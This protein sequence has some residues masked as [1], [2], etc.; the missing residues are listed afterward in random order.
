MTK[1]FPDTRTPSKNILKISKNKTPVTN[2][3]TLP[4]DAFHLFVDDNMIQKIVHYTNIEGKREKGKE[5]QDTDSTEIQSFIGCLLHTGA[6]HQNDLSLEMLFSPVDGNSLVRAAFGLRRFSSL[7]NHLRFDD[8]ATRS[9]RRAR[10]V[11]A[12]IRELWDLFH[13]NLGKHYVAGQNITVDE[14]LVPFRG[15]CSFIQYMPSKP[16]KYGLKFFWASDAASNYPLRGFPY[17]EKEA[18][19][20]RPAE[21]TMGIAASTVERLTQDV[22]GTGRNI[23]CDNYFTDLKLAESLAKQK[24]TMIGTVKRNKTFLPVDFQAKKALPLGESK[25]LFR[26]ETTLVSFQSKRP[27]NVILLST[28]HQK[29]EICPETTKPDIVLHYNKTKGGVDAMDQM[30]HAFTTKRKTKRWPLVVFFNILDLSSIAA[31][32]IFQLK[33]PVDKLSHEDCRQRFN[34]D[35]G[36]SM[37]YAH[38][39]RR[40]SVPTLQKEVKVNISVVIKSIKPVSEQ[41][42]AKPPKRARVEESAPS[43]KKQK[44]CALCPAK[45]DRKTKSTCS[46][47]DC[48]IC[49]EHTVLF[50]QNCHAATS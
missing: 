29:P 44:R 43:A 38:I 1:P 18:T 39:V 45:R 2:H 23:T 33:Y 28:T 6:L 12:P 17:L 7:L 30:A 41:M 20:A 14:Q 46:S 40:S 31:R 22:K 49:Q 24:L 50:C 5:W 21:R 26:H 36:R 47:C 16:D 15:R 37:A 8:K 4:N 13:T 27:K 34:A 48:H 32:V 42:A 35:V 3:V 11:F 9:A 19:S 10:D 25:F